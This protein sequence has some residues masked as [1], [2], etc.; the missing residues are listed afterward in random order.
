MDCVLNLII[1]NYGMG[2]SHSDEYLI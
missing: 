1:N 2:D